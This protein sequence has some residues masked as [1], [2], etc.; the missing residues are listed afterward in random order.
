MG[1]VR[2]VPLASDGCEEDG[3]RVSGRRSDAGAARL[4]RRRNEGRLSVKARLVGKSWWAP[5]GR[6]TGRPVEGHE[7]DG[8]VPSHQSKCIR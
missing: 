1:A 8:K 6:E 3:D 7:A 5:C 4:A 2:Q